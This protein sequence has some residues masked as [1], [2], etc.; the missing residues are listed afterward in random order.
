MAHRRRFRVALDDLR[1][2]GR[3]LLS[4]N[5]LA[6]VPAQVDRASPTSIPAR[7][8]LFHHDGINGLTLHQ[9]FVNRLNDRLQTS[10][11]QASRVA[12]AFQVFQTRYLQVPVNS[13]AGS[14]GAAVT[15]LLAVLQ[16]Q[17]D[18]A[19][20]NREILNGRPQPSVRKGLKVS[21]LAPLAL[22][23]YA[24]EQIG[25]L[26][27]TLAATPPVSGPDGAPVPA[28]PTPALN[29]AINAIFNALAES[30]V[31][32]NLFQ[33]P[34]DFYI[35]PDVRFTITSTG[36]PAASSPGYFIRGPQGEILPGAPPRP[37][38]SL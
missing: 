37:N 11:S 22:V 15:G 7:S 27:A 4:R 1:L 8:N 28:D 9:S 31:H 34:S 29:T 5:G 14:S 16:N 20:T 36:P 26:G 2:E 12:Q 24:N 23:P 6:T 35:S 19:L 32:P 17:V 13:P 25:Q 33:S 3:Q 30:S 10:G 21:P 38:V 18:F